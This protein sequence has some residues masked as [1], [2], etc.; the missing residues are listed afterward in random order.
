MAKNK[1]R[2]FYFSFF[3]FLGMLPMGI[4]NAFGQSPS[5]KE[6]V[7]A[8]EA[9]Q[10][11][12]YIQAEKGY[13]KALELDPT[14]PKT[15]YNLGNTYY[16][17]GK[18]DKAKAY[19]DQSLKLSKEPLQKAKANYNQGNSYF[20]EKNYQK[21]IEKYKQALR[22]NPS[23]KDSR[24]N[25]TLAQKKLEEKKKEQDKQQNNSDQQKEKDPQNSA[26][27]QDQNKDQNNPQPKDQEPNKDPNNQKDPNEKGNDNQKNQKDPNQQENPSNS[28]QNQPKGQ[29]PYSQAMLEAAARQEQ[30]SMKRK[31]QQAQEL[32]GN[33]NPKDW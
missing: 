2:T 25:L 29:S 1:M 16:K 10:K 20:A 8:A 26:N 5:K 32:S 28:P 7:K 13:L 6:S 9:Y 17:Q 30:N 14:N 23:D 4:F 22:E 3:L 12:E 21:A 18:L 24:Y 27:N 33:K 19:Y 15:A 31:F 11:G